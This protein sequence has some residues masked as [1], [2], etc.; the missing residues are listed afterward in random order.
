M[1][2]KNPSYDYKIRDTIINDNTYVQDLGLIFTSDLKPSTQ[3]LRAAARAHKMISI[4]NLAFKYLDSRSLSI[5]YKSLVRP[6]LDYCCVAWCPYYT[7]DIEVLEK[8]QRRFT[9][10]VPGLKHMSYNDRLDTLKLQTLYARRLRFDL[11][12]AY[13]IIHGFMNVDAGFFFEF[14]PDSRTRGHNFK[15]QSHFTRTDVRKCFFTSRVISQWNALP[16]PCAEA[17]NIS[18]FKNELS[19]HFLTEGIR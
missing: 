8:V 13:K 7:K 4:I 18:T 14:C 15:L 9:R 1:G 10:L 16:A 5:L 2:F 12:T 11:I 19:K 6:I 3:C 17:I